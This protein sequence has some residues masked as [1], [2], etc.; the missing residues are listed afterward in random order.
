MVMRRT[1]EKGRRGRRVANIIRQI[2]SEELVMR[3]NDPRL[4][5][6]TV[7][8]V[9]LAADLRFA[10][11][12]ISVLGDAKQQQ[13]CLRAIK[14][15]HGHLQEKVASVLVLKF[16]PVLRFHMDE[17]IKRSVS[18]SAI[19][20]KARAEDEARRA[21]RIARGVE[22]S[23]EM[24]EEMEETPPQPIHDKAD[25]APDDS[26]EDFDEDPDDDPDDDDTDDAGDEE[27]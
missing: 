6:V 15:A 16:C 5:F 26:D 24:Q 14:H 9:D 21:D 8:G 10:D 4:A 22:P 11:V 12:R 25:E 17:S 2:V 19:I 23:P 20:A 1:S 7:T 3:L 18:L 13:D 27:L